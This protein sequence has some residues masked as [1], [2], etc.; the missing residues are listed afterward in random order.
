MSR[1][2]VWWFGNCGGG[3]SHLRAG[4]TTPGSC[5][6][7]SSSRS[8]SGTALAPSACG[9][10]A[11]R[12]NAVARAVEGGRWE[13]GRW[14]RRDCA[15][16]DAAGVGRAVVCLRAREGDSANGAGDANGDDNGDD[17]GEGEGGDRATWRTAGRAA[18]A[19]GAG[20]ASGCCCGSPCLLRNGTPLSARGVW[21]GCCGCCG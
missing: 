18:A 15:R 3:K 9:D 10:S 19:E 7:P 6:K 2:A 11:D 21:D 13:E 4:F 17:N 8:T 14:R 16:G 5:S 1:T 12:C 20:R